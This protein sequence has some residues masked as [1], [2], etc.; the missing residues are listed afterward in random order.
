MVGMAQLVRAS[1]CGPE[2]R[3]FESH[4]SPHK[5]KHQANAWCFVLSRVRNGI[6]APTSASE[7][8]SRSILACAQSVDNQ[9]LAL[10]AGSESHFLICN[11]SNFD[12]S[13]G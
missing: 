2:G 11:N 9:A 3:G 12:L 1:G 13:F 6:Y 10:D 4:Y 5:T 8:S 7:A